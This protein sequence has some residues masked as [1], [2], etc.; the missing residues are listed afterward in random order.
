MDPGVWGERGVEFAC[1]LIGYVF[2]DVFCCG[3][4]VVEGWDVVEVLVV[5]GLA[6]LDEG[7]FEEV[8]IAEEPFGVELGAGDCGGG[9]EVV[10]VGW[11]GGA[12]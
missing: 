2:G 8:E 4:E 10:A 7:L 1:Q 12:V 3:V 6:D 11:F 9:S 5:E